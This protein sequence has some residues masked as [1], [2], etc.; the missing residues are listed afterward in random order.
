MMEKVFNVLFQCRDFQT[1][2]MLFT[3][4]R[5]QRTQNT[6]KKEKRQT[7]LLVC[8]FLS[9]WG[10]SNARPLRPERSALPTA[11]HSALE[12]GATSNRKSVCIA[13]FL[14]KLYLH[15]DVSPLNKVF[16][17]LHR[18][19]QFCVLGSISACKGRYLFGIINISKKFF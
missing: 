11:L 10:D 17:T 13:L 4:I 8:R 12:S 6:V 19:T 16:T 9:E 18:S 1:E 7:I 2:L 14:N 3:L 5:N 15:Y